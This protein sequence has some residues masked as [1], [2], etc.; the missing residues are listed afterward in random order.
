MVDIFSLKPFDSEGIKAHIVA[1]KGKVV[2]AEETYEAG[3]AFEAVCSAGVGAI[4][5]I[6]QLCVRSVPGSATPQEQLE[7]QGL[8]WK[9]IEKNIRELL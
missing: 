3:G 1:S 5:S 6:R 8:D 2:V 9:S 7:L 4:A